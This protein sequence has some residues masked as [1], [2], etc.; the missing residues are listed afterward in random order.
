[1]ARSYKDIGLSEDTASDSFELIELANAGVEELTA[2]FLAIAEDS[3]EPLVLSG[4][5]REFGDSGPLVH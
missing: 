5:D 1:M 2:L 4:V 3:L